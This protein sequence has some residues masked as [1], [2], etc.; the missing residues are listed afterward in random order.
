MTAGR[1]GER[2]ISSEGVEERQ[3]KLTRDFPEV[4]GTVLCACYIGPRIVLGTSHSLL[5]WDGVTLQTLKSEKQKSFSQLAVSDEYGILLSLSA[6]S[7]KNPY[8][9][10]YDLQE[11]HSG[12]AG[13]AKIEE[14]KNCQFFDLSVDAESNELRLAVLMKKSV[15]LFVWQSTTSSFLK[16]KEFPVSEQTVLVKLVGDSLFIAT[17]SEI[18]VINTRDASSHTI[19]LV[20]GASKI[21]P[22][23]IIQIEKEI[24]LTYNNI[25][26][27]VSAEGK[28]VRDVVFKWSAVPTG[29]A[30]LS[31]LVIGFTPTQAEI[32][33]PVSGNLLET[34]SLTSTRF[35]SG[36]AGINPE[37]LLASSSSIA[38]LTLV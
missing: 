9:F 6:K 8:I 1:F 3:W 10:H 30:Y 21:E 2:T 14:T 27:T 28:R 22:V 34:K 29:V 24:L 35:L 26:F 7:G 17:K 15:L 37:A 19:P 13:G 20:D 12:S 16:I 32:R 5:Y 4:E 25:S 11:I 33:S 36:S 31:P 18:S 38:R 23:S